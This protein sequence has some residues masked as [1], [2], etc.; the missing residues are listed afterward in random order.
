MQK[1][2]CCHFPK[3]LIEEMKKGGVS[4]VSEEH[5]RK[6]KF[7][8]EGKKKP[9]Y[10][11]KYHAPD[12]FSE[13]ILTEGQDITGVLPIDDLY[14]VDL[15]AI[16]LET[17]N[18]NSAILLQP[19]PKP[20]KVI[21]PFKFEKS[22]EEE[23]IPTPLPPK[24]TS[25]EKKFKFHFSP[26][27]IDTDILLSS[28]C[29]TAIEKSESVSDASEKYGIL[30]EIAVFICKSMPRKG[31]YKIARNRIHNAQKAQNYESLKTALETLIK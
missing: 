7:F 14:L 2:S 16:D 22:S 15:E 26:K 31:E 20:K 1:I 25:T 28:I 6:I 17:L 18:Q 19:K 27:L 4:V 8:A 29:R 3:Y 21:E 23:D 24:K 5:G 13:L 10:A 11:I 30:D 9:I 12:R